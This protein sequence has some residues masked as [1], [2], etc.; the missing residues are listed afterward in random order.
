MLERNILDLLSDQP[1]DCLQDIQ[2]TDTSAIL[3]MLSDYPQQQALA[4]TLLLQSRW[5]ILDRPQRHID[6]M[7]ILLPPTSKPELPITGWLIARTDHMLSQLSLADKAIP[8]REY[9]TTTEELDHRN[10][11]KRIESQFHSDI[12]HSPRPFSQ[13]LREH[14]DVFAD[15]FKRQVSGLPAPLK[16]KVL[17]LFEDREQMLYVI[18]RS[19]LKQ[20][21]RL[22]GLPNELATDISPNLYN[23]LVCPHDSATQEQKL[24]A[25]EIDHDFVSRIALG[26]PVSLHSRPDYQHGHPVH[27]LNHLI[28]DPQMSISDAVQKVKSEITDTHWKKVKNATE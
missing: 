25:L 4:E 19:L 21:L 2:T 17:T 9:L 6:L 24:L 5:R 15:E 13:S 22:T 16:A 14:H 20:S 12:D 23:W 26:I 8:L 7:L 28:S 1:A 18:A 27:Y 3:T 11:F 10:I